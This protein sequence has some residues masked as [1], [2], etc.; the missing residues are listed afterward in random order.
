MNLPILAHNTCVDESHVDHGNRRELTFRRPAS[1]WTKLFAMTLAA[2]ILASAAVLS[3]GAGEAANSEGD[4]ALLY[5]AGDLVR[6]AAS[7]VGGTT[8]HDTLGADKSATH[9]PL[10]AGKHLAYSTKRAG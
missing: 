2:L 4:G 3:P 6:V 5:P 7:H 1:W 9:G 8:H 10:I